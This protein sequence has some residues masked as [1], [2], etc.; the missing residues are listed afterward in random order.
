LLATTG[1]HIVNGKLLLRYL[2]CFGKPRDS[3]VAYVQDDTVYWMKPNI[4]LKMEIGVVEE[5]NKERVVVLKI[6]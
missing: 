6:V 1:L 4:G 5:R 2:D 3:L